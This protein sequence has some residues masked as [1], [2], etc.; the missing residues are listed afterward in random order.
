MLTISRIIQKLNSL[1]RVVFILF[2]LLLPIMGYSQYFLEKDSAESSFTQRELERFSRQKNRKIKRL[3]LRAKKTND[4]YLNAFIKYEEKFLQGMCDYNEYRAEALIT[5]AWYSYNRFENKLIRSASLSDQKSFGVADSGFVALVFIKK[6]LLNS[7]NINHK[8]GSYL[9]SLNFEFRRTSLISE[10]ILDRTGFLLKSASETSQKEMQK[11]EMCSYYFVERNK[12]LQ[13]L[14]SLRSNLEKRIIDRLY[15]N[16]SYLSNLSASKFLEPELIEA[17]SSGKKI[18]IDELLAKAP[19]E[20]KENIAKFQ[21]LLNQN[22]MIEGDTL[23]IPVD[24]HK[25]LNDCEIVSSDTAYNIPS[26]SNLISTGWKP[27]RLRSK[28][29]KDRLIYGMNTQ[30]E[31]QSYFIPTSFGLSAQIGYRVTTKISLGSGFSYRFSID[32][33]LSKQEQ[34]KAKS[35]SF[36]TDQTGIGFIGYMNYSLSKFIYL[37]LEY[38][39]MGRTVT[40]DE[41]LE[42]L[43]WQNSA[44]LGLK[45]VRSSSKKQISPT[46]DVLLNLMSRD[47]RQQALIVRLGFQLNSKNS[48]KY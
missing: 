24:Y 38:D 42:V 12:E 41:N 28:S 23:G 48:L 45:M 3:H 8:K 14:L 43:Q 19:I 27:N 26:E 29:T 4:R 6:N 5:D 1:I 36:G 37:H 46:I 20:T 18:K 30:F 11:M 22:K 35:K 15:L 32:S 2:L 21:Q 31:K 47:R 16:S 44:L 7:T 39:L 9:D 34:N 25:K 10:Y 33:F 13:G 17:S 40:K